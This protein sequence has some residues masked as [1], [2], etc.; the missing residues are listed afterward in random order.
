MLRLA[1]PWDLELLVDMRFEDAPF[2]DVPNVSLDGRGGD[3]KRI[4]AGRFDL[5]ALV[6]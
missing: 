2:I 6:R 3:A 1:D 5:D 4:D